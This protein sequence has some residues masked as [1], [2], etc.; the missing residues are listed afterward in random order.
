MQLLNTKKILNDIEPLG[1]IPP[2]RILIR[3]TI[4]M[5]WPTILESFL[6]SSVIMINMMMV[7]TLGANAV[8]A[9]GLVSQPRLLSIS[10]IFSLNIA[11]SA[12]IARK[13]GQ[14]DRD[15]A[16]KVL[17]QAMIITVILTLVISFLCVK[18]ADPIMRFAGSEPETH[19]DSV[20]FFKIVM[21]G[22]IFTTVTMVNNAAQRGAGNTKI[23][24]RT[25]MVANLVTVACNF[26]L[27][28][29]RFGAPALGV[30]GAAI[31]T[32]IGAG[33]G[34]AM[35]I[36]SVSHKDE[37]VYF[38]AIKY[39]RLEKATLK[40]ITK[41]GAPSLAEQLMLRAGFL[42]YAIMVAHLGTVTFATYQI[43][44]QFLILSFSFGDGLSNA[45][46]ALVGRSLGEERRDLAKIYGSICQRMGIIFSSLCALVFILLGKRLFMLYSHDPE[47]LQYALLT[48]L[49]MSYITYMQISQVVF[50][51]CLRGAGDVVFV[52]YASFITVTIIRP[53]SGFILCYVFRL[54]LFGVWL[55]V[56]IDQTMRLILTSIRFAGGKWMYHKI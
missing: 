43:G 33:A 20:V 54:G 55:S 47:I 22:I 9:V 50:S 42:I 18:F 15:G 8:A 39:F 45:S 44:M 41:I 36:Y 34:C 51:G 32:L 46:I 14:S 4:Q 21:G 37:F 31:S 52:A 3:T 40:T 26:F 25:N 38:Q 6:I 10:F 17:V 2:N 1:S 23:S 24:M 53:L 56:S 28:S 49:F 27:I 5:A 13:R 30:E 19:A 48:M 11:V 35:S 16:N 29:G 7:S 12:I